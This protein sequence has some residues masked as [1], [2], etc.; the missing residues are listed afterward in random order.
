M[1]LFLKLASINNWDIYQ[2]DVN[3]A[4]LNAKLNVKVY[5]KIPMYG[6]GKKKR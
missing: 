3:C 1:R 4:N 5:L 2:L 6:E